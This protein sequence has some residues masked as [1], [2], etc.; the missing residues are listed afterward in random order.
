MGPDGP[1]SL[2][3]AIPS[4]TKVIPW[5]D[6]DYKGPLGKCHSEGQPSWKMLC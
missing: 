5:L 6:L 3:K 1:P 4:S 2:T